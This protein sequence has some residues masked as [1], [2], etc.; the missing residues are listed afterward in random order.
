VQWSPRG[1]ETG[2]LAVIGVGLA[3]AVLV[4]DAAGK[5]LIGLAAVLVLALVVRDVVARPRLSAGPD[6][7][8]VRS[9]TARR[10]LPW[11]LLRVRVRESRRFGIRGRTLEL[12]TASGPDDDGV[13]VV[14][15]R[16]DLGADPEVVARE[17]RA[18]DPTAGR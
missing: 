16:R 12:D 7:V 2:A 18:L 4:V 15:G 6:G 9:W 13:L 10:H 17:L 1:A 5:V 11:P 14:L 8:D 3:L